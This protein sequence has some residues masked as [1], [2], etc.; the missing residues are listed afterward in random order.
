MRPDS[1]PSCGT[2]TAPS[3][4]PSRTGWRPRRRWS[5][6][7]AGRGRTS[8]RCGLVGL[9]LEDSARI[10]QAAG[11]AHGRPRH[12]RPPHRRRHAPA[13]RRPACRSVPARASCSPSLR[14]AGIKTGARDD[15][16]AA[17]GETVVDLIDFEA[18]DVVIAGDDA[19]RPKPFPDPYLQACEALGVAPA[20]TV[21]I[22]DSPERAALRRRVRRRRDRRAAHGVDRRRRRATPCGR[23]SRDAPR[24]T[25]RSFHAAPCPHPIRPRRSPDDHDHGPSGPFRLGDRVQLTGPKG[26]L[27]TITL[28]ED[29][30]LHTHHG[31]L[32]HTQLIGQPD[33]SVVANSGG[34][35]YLA[36]RPLLR[37]FVM[38]MPRGAAIVY[39]KDA[40]QILAEA[41]VFPG[42]VV[43]EA[44]VGSGA[45]S[46]WLL[47]AIGADGAPRVVRAPRRVRRRRA[48][49]RRDLHRG[50]AGELGRRRRR[51]GRGAARRGGRGIR[52]SRRP[53]HA[54]AVGVHRRRRRRAHARRRRALLHRDRDAA[55]P[56]RGVHPRHRAVHRARGERDD[57]ARLARRGTRGAPRPPH[58]RAHRLPAV[59]APA[60]AGRRRRPR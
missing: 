25:W 33:G 41:D 12:H 56:R 44:G 27:H 35:E 32:R 39:P 55:E 60:R 28:R 31:V 37:D 15:V 59:G 48:R 17:D 2:W 5:R 22:E 52:R 43:V 4:T 26:R 51:S 58:D 23:R 36:L 49:E 6:A 38:S 57:G 21:A 18:F 45:L 7:S 47:R 19:T 3:S 10:F 1:P 29:G 50:G 46:L 13:R 30:E 20:E 16:D 8:R 34:H 42:A 24:R 14:E 53:R 9:G 40:A 11:R 54:G